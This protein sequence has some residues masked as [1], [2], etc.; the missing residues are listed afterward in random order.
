[1]ENKRPEK[2][3]VKIKNSGCNSEDVWDRERK[4]E[5]E[6]DD[7]TPEKRDKPTWDLKK[8]LDKKERKE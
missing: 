2:T 3:N 6:R 8:K 1:M 5:K 7:F 4:K